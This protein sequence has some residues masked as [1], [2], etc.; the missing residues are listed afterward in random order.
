M[1]MKLY[2]KHKIVPDDLLNVC[3]QTIAAFVAFNDFTKGH[4][5]DSLKGTKSLST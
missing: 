3:L 2:E 1:T 5:T 4:R